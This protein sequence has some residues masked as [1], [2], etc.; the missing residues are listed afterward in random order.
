LCPPPV[1]DLVYYT[2]SSTF[3]LSNSGDAKELAWVNANVTPG[4]FAG[5]I[6][7]EPGGLSWVSD[8]AYPVV[9]V[10]AATVYA[11]YLNVVPGQAL[12]SQSFNKKG[13]RQEISH[14]SLFL[15]ADVG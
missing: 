5:P 13:E 3:E 9:L 15:C 6:K 7:L 14:V 1:C 11:I 10:K 12:W 4:P 2:G 8:G